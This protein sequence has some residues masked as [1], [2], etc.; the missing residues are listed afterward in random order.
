MNVFGGVGFDNRNEFVVVQVFGMNGG[1][2][3]VLFCYIEDI[4]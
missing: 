1:N 4:E 2:I 3:A